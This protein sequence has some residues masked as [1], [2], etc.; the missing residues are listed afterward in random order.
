M[1]GVRSGL[2]SVF[3]EIRPEKRSNLCALWGLERPEGVGE[4]IVMN[5]R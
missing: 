3:S 2:I 4:R 1:H 5:F